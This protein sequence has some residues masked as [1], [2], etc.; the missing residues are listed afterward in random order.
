MRPAEAEIVSD[1]AALQTLQDDWRRLALRRG[2]AFVTPE[3]FFTWF[4]HYG[5]EHEPV[6]SVVRHAD[7][8]M[9][10]IM[11][12]ALSTSTRPRSLRFAGAN[13][14][15]SFHPVALETDE[16]TV[17]AATAA[18]LP[19]LDRA[20]STV[21]LDNIE[22]DAR[23]PQELVSASPRRLAVMELRRGILPFISVGGLGWEEFQRQRSRKI[24]RERARC[25]RRLEESHDV[26]FRCTQ[27]G[28]TLDNDVATLFRLH[29]FRFGRQGG[30]SLASERARAFLREFA[31]VTL[32][33][34]WLRL[35]FLEIDGEPVAAS[36]DLRVGGRH[37]CYQSGF[38]PAWS[39]LGVG[40]VLEDHGIRLAVEEGAE[41]F[42][43]LFG[44]EEY[45]LRQ[46]TSARHV[47]SLVA[48]RSLHPARLLAATDVALRRAARALPPR[49]L[50][51]ARKLA[52][53]APRGL[54]SARRR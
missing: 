29:D 30:S 44:D 18:A 13:L 19:R 21:V 4:A 9:A 12:L 7:G 27:G 17:A 51:R 46:A 32:A 43:F 31:A 45:K 39:R 52:R 6:V 14:G 24:R 53:A 28:E 25:L 20:W 15:D 33:R 34:G 2:N 11:P 48:V 37:A 41:T 40:N 35:C 50:A 5:D 3:W 1:P 26:R 36:Y 38:D 22:V 49:L 47:H 23:W 54:P 16:E 8:V 42:D 10:G